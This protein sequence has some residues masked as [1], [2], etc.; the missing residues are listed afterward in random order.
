MK[1]L[2]KCLPGLILLNSCNGQTSNSESCKEAY[3]YAMSKLN[4]Y[5]V[6]NNPLYLQESLTK[7][8]LA[9]SCPKTRASSI[10]LK[11]SLLLLLKMYDQGI[12]F[13]DSLTEEDFKFKYKLKMTHDYF[14][15]LQT[16][17]KGDSIG[18][19]KI[20]AGII[21]NIN[22]FI[23]TD[24]ISKGKLNEEAYYDLYVMKA[25]VM[26]FQTVESEIKLLVEKYPANKDFF[27][28]L[29]SSLNEHEKIIYPFS[30]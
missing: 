28:A 11:I 18:A 23:Q 27:H 3:K 13:I 15:V 8:D 1:L 5:Y 4:K 24:T 10:E 6:E 21:S 9:I 7:I 26:S 20:M 19:S 17:S 14:Q 25:G 29:I 22:K 2:I 30:K 16:K 12:V